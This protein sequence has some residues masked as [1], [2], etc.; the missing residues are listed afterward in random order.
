MADIEVV[1]KIPE[2]YYNAIKVIPD[3]QCTADMLIIK[4]STPLPKG[5]G[6]LIDAK[7]LGEDMRICQK[8]IT[9]E[10]VLIGFN[11]AVALCNK[12]LAESEDEE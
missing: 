11:M 5:H 1:I 4:T 10:K 2:E 6:R 7:A 12:H 8:T 9:D 3:R